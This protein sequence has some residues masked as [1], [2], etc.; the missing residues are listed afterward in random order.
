MSKSSSRRSLNTDEV[1]AIGCRVDHGDLV[2]MLADGREVRSE[3][4]RYPRLKRATPAQLAN[5]RLVGRGVGLNWP[6]LDED[7]SVAGLLRDGVTTL[8]PTKLAVWRLSFAASV[9]NTVSM[10]LRYGEPM[11]MRDVPEA[12]N[13]TS[14]AVSPE[15]KALLRE[16]L[17]H[18]ALH[19]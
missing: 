4:A 5:W 16:L 10:S 13:S 19:A 17:R 9:A 18:E 7:L 6:D 2:V 15:Q 3:L 11:N 8:P 1:R 14:F 12:A